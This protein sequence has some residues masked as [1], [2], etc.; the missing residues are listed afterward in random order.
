M[1]EAG[2]LAASAGIVRRSSDL[3]GSL[4]CMEREVGRACG[5]RMSLE[6]LQLLRPMRPIPQD[7]P[8]CAASGSLKPR[9]YTR[10]GRWHVG[11]GTSEWLCLDGWRGAVNFLK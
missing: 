9:I 5:V 8:L 1:C 10:D 11:I 2:V 4:G 6:I 7:L 3:Y